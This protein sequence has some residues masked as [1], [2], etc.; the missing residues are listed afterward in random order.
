MNLSK[1]NFG[2]LCFCW[3]VFLLLGLAVGLNAPFILALIGTVLYL[4]V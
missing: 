3:T 2:F 1:T 4:I